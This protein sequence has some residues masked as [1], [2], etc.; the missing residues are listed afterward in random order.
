MS[1]H[2]LG[3]L[4][5]PYMQIHIPF[6]SKYLYEVLCARYEIILTGFCSQ[7]SVP[8]SRREVKFYGTAILRA[9]W[10]AARRTSTKLS[11]RFELVTGFG[12]WSRVT[13]W[14]YAEKVQRRSSPGHTV[15]PASFRS[16]RGE[17]YRKQII[18]CPSEHSR[19]VHTS[20]PTNFNLKARHGNAHILR[21]A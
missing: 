8:R 11:S 5:T 9:R 19:A 2:S 14:S 4:D 21:L 3:G 13:A 7:D 17:V 15:M 1:C 10:L 20:S 18:V 16:G 6:P 12:N